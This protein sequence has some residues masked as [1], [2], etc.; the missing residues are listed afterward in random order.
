MPAFLSCGVP[1]QEDGSRCSATTWRRRGFGMDRE[2]PFLALCVRRLFSSSFYFCSGIVQPFCRSIGFWSSILRSPSLCHPFKAL[3]PQRLCAVSATHAGCAAAHAALTL[4]VPAPASGKTW[5]SIANSHGATRWRWRRDGG[6]L[7]VI[8]WAAIL[9][10]LGRQ[11]VRLLTDNIDNE[12][13]ERR[14]TA[15]GVSLWC[16]Y[17]ARGAFI[18]SCSAKEGCVSDVTRD[19]DAG[20]SMLAAAGAEGRA[21]QRLRAKCYSVAARRGE[22]SARVA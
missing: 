20:G 5:R 11:R 7:A 10:M 22:R 12:R 15:C 17:A 14:A 6:S 8:T 18:F 13:R 4:S 19:A 21:L 3:A 2:R 1:G 16:H 9:R